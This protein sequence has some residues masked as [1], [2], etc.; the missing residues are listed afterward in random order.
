M[1]ATAT[2][3]KN[4]LGRYLRFIVYEDVII[5]SHG[6]DVAV[7]SRFV[8]DSIQMEEQ[9]AIYKTGKWVS[10]EEFII[11]TQNSDERYELI[12][13]QI[14]VMDSPLFPHQHAVTKI[15]SVMS[16][17]FEKKKCMPVVAPFDVTLIKNTNNICVVQPD[18][19][20]ICD[21]ENISGKGKYKGVPSLVVEVLSN[22]TKGKDRVLK[23]NLYMKAGVNEYWMVDTKNKRLS[24]F[25]F[26]DKKL[27]AELIFT[28]DDVA[29]SVLF[30]GLS[31][32]LSD[33][34]I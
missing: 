10:Y 26:S 24:I 11:M 21:K 9:E 2:E 22:S 8:D 19:L 23:L 18:I 5:S 6:K 33:I 32:N 28:G 25:V 13:G 15:A 1:R 20:V 29:E 3:V 7:L 17:W 14:F 4:N 27:D 16:N 30:E 12:D 31:L 34:F